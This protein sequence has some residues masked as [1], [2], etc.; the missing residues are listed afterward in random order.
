MC[1]VWYVLLHIE[2]KLVLDA[3]TSNSRIVYVV[4]FVSVGG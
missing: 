1:F 3:I 4:T 2:L